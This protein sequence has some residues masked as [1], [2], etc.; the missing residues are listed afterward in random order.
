S[1]LVFHMLLRTLQIPP[2]FVKPCLPTPAERPPSGLARFTNQAQWLPHDGPARGRQGIHRFSRPPS[3][4]RFDGNGTPAPD[5]LRYQRQDARVFLFAFDLLELNGQDIRREPL[6]MRKRQLATLL[7][8]AR[9]GL[10]LN[11]HLE[12]E[13]GAVVFRHACKLGLEAL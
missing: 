7:R 12:H 11:E 9:F 3:R 2:G 8:N 6:E 1:Y 5:R 10:Q 4:S 13:D